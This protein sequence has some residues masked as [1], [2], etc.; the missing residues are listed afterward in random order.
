MNQFD[1]NKFY[2]QE[3]QDLEQIAQI[4]V[5]EQ[6]K[7]IVVILNDWIS[8]LFKKRLV[9]I[10]TGVFLTFVMI[11]IVA[12]V[13]D[14]VQNDLIDYINN[15]LPSLADLESEATALYDAAREDTNSDYEMYNMIRNEVLPVAREWKDA[16]EDIEVE[17]E[18]VRELHEIYIKMVNENYNAMTIIL[19]ALEN[20]DYALVSQ[21]NEKLD[22]VR[23]LGRDFKSELKKLM[24]KHGV[25]FE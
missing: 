4:Q 18:E 21:A 12:C 22:Y 3:N 19:S 17:T 24:D 20:Q 7:K 23:K 9:R 2:E 6:P 13:N 25:V 16:T 14:P 5:E 15:D 8:A 1:E 11:M 10:G